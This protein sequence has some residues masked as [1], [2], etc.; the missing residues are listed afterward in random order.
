MS[1]QTHRSL[2]SRSDMPSRL[3]YRHEIDGLRAVAVLPVIF[4][5]AGFSLFQG[6]YVGVDVFFVI[7]GYLITSLILAEQTAGTFT[8]AGFYDRR[9]RRILP[10]LFLVTAACLGMA[11]L[12]MTPLQLKE[13]FQSVTAISV[14]SSNVLF[15]RLTSEYFASAAEENPLLH[16]WSLGVEEQY[17]I[18]FPVLVV[19]LWY[20]DR[21]H[22]ARWMGI[23]LFISLAL[24]EYGS[25][26]Q[27]IAN[28][29][30][31]PSRAWELLVGA[32]VAWDSYGH[33]PFHAR[34]SRSVREMLTALGL[35][36]ICLA[37]LIFGVQT[38]FPSLYALVPTIGAALVIGVGTR[39]TWV[40]RLLS[41]PFVV[42]IGLIS[43]SVYLWHQ[44][45][46]A[47]ARLYSI[48][49]LSVLQIWALI[50]VTFIF[51][52]LTW[53]FVERPFRDRRKFSRAQI[54]AGAAFASVGFFAIGLVGHLA[55]GFPS[56]FTPAELAAIQAPRSAT[57][58]CGTV[59]LKVN[60]A[61]KRCDIGR[62]GGEPAIV[63]T[64]DSHAD[65]I[66]G[67]LGD[68]LTASGQSGMVLRNWACGPIVGLYSPTLSTKEN[69]ASCQTAQKQFLSFVRDTPS[70]RDVIVA[71]RWT[72]QLYPVPGEIVKLVYD[73]GE[74][75][76]Y[77]NLPYKE[78]AALK[79]DG[80][81][82]VD[83]ELK[84]KTVLDFLSGLQS[85]GKRIVLIYPVPEV[86]WDVPQLAMKKLIRGQR[87]E[88]VTT[89]YSRFL[90]RNR[91]ASST[92]DQYTGSNVAR[93]KPANVLCNTI[94]QDRCIA[95][96]ENT[97]L[98]FD[99]N[100]LSNSGAEA[101]VREILKVPERTD[102]ASQG[103]LVNAVAR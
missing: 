93:V 72:M 35:G 57:I 94:V 55:R 20:V 65:A 32:L 62:K 10:A 74:G 60:S 49:K 40:A 44:P 27:P 51:A 56:R 2:G 46:L 24:C 47:F 37:I 90:Q 64:G 87:L 85:T 78:S 5:H 63:L 13:F 86:G 30:L 98:Y 84:T 68:H 6:G 67:V 12:F 15:W 97:P 22:L 21:K 25:R 96:I 80:T 69:V 77:D 48:N 8:I 33:R 23:L 71:I 95:Q 66:G 9:A 103:A 11:W 28:F 81:F 18:L 39:D 79:P 38:R 1:E 76:T 52:Y 102:T 16:T 58:G 70:I 61:I 89:S 17:Y 14:F 59:S 92:L 99:D 50:F 43:Y 101:V 31:A 54:F 42:R 7:S 29:F 19:G 4:F 45:L 88:T 91:F 3:D 73:N 75:G 36:L 100:H 53:L 83:G 26:S 41:L 82:G 34:I